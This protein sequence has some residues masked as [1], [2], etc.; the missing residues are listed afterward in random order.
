MHGLVEASRHWPAAVFVPP[1]VKSELR[2][3]IQQGI[4]ACADRLLPT[5]AVLP[6]SWSS[7][8]GSQHGDF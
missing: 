1:S 3:L 6:T 8:E 5:D 7:A 2:A 4:D